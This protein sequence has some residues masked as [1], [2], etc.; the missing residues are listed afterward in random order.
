MKKQSTNGVSFKILASGKGWLAVD[1]PAGISVH[2]DPGQDLC[3]LVANHLQTDA[4]LKNTTGLE[5]QDRLSAAHR[6]DRETS[7]IIL[8][9]GKKSLLNHFAA[10]FETRTVDKRYT[11]IVHGRLPLAVDPDRWETWKWTLTKAA[12]GRQNP[13]GKGPRKTCTTLVRAL[14]HSRHYTLVACRLLTGRKHQI[15]RH[16]KLAGHPVVGDRRY[17]SKKALDFLRTH[18]DFNRLALHAARLE[19]QLPD[20]QPLALSAQPL[21]LEMQQLFDGDGQSTD[22]PGQATS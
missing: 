18:H 15:R 19:I 10:Q 11:A 2:N 13:R 12:G 14:A 6:L 22:L 3:T 16:A 7:G 4:D 17:G 5:G 1:K 9:A 20:G 21:P 8:L